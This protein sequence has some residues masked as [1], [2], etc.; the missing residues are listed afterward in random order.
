M[1]ESRL[2]YRWAILALLGLLLAGCA[3]GP[4]EGSC[5]G[6]RPDSYFVVGQQNNEA[7]IWIVEG[8]KKERVTVRGVQ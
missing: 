7:A 3:T 2:S 8:A 6:P 4:M 1:C 5:R